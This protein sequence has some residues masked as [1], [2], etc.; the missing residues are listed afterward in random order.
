MLILQQ[1]FNDFSMILV[2]KSTHV[3][4]AGNRQPVHRPSDMG[5]RNREKH[6]GN[7]SLSLSGKIWIWISQNEALDEIEFWPLCILFLIYSNHLKK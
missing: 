7:P 2:G 1:D 4:A 3:G 5:A 6:N